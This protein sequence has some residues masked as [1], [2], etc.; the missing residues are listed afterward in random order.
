MLGKID[1]QHNTAFMV[2]HS[3]EIAQP[4]VATSI[5]YRLGALGF[6]ATPEGK[7]FALYDQ[8][9]ALLWIQK[10]I[11]GFGGDKEKLTVFGE[12]A[13]GYSICMHMLSNPPP[14]GPLFNRAIIMSGIPGPLMTPQSSVQAEI[15]FEETLKALKITERGEDA[16][17]K[18][19]TLD[20]QKIVDASDV[21]TSKGNFWPPVEDNAWFKDNVTWDNIGELLGRCDWV[22]ALILGNTGFEGAAYLSLANDMTPK[23]FHDH[24]VQQLDQKAATT[25]MELYGMTLD[26]DQNL[27]L[28]AAMR[29]FGELAF[30]G[31]CIMFHFLPHDW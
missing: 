3:I 9:N 7:N 5:Q 18:L 11:N 8:R 6:M 14:N 27:F 10:F 19:R 17:E 29:W 24:I 20:V 23:R 1:P 2:Q 15:A 16:M 4:I 13:G 30:D 25:A 22:D 12:S 28:T 31:T 21:W 26:M